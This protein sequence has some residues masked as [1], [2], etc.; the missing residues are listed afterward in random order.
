MRGVGPVLGMGTGPTPPCSGRSAG[1]SPAPERKPVPGSREEADARS[2]R[3]V[4]F[5]TQGRRQGFPQRGF[6]R[7][8][9]PLSP[10][11]GSGARSSRRNDSAGSASA[12]TIGARITEGSATA[13]T[14]TPS[15]P[16]CPATEPGQTPTREQNP[17]GDS[18]PRGAA[19]REI[20][21]G[22]V[23]HADTAS[24]SHL[25]ASAGPSGPNPGRAGRFRDRPAVPAPPAAPA[26]RRDGARTYRE[27]ADA[28]AASRARPLRPAH[29]PMRPG[30]VSKSP[31][32]AA[33]IRR[34]PDASAS[35]PWRS[36]V[37]PSISRA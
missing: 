29:R 3:P 28:A 32:N 21:G 25:L 11:R 1:R 7:P 4:P 20:A 14:R 34:W 13:R 12:R 9:R 8:D 6:H 31:E 16:H 17:V 36:S 35:R 33:A 19:R 2:G 37:R 5:A 24:G 15:S 30:P 18:P 23:G 27:S 10:V 22:S 26:D